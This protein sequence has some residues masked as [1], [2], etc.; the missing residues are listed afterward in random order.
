MITAEGILP[1]AGK[2]LLTASVRTVVSKIV[3]TNLT[4]D[5]KVYLYKY[6]YDSGIDVVPVYKYELDAGDM[7]NDVNNYLLEKGDYLFAKTD[8]AG[9][10]YILEADDSNI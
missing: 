3:F 2:T 7:V 4:V 8:V 1:I 5:Y 9:T 10:T 6:N